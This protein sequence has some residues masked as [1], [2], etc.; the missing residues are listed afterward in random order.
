[1]KALWEKVKAF[2]NRLGPVLKIGAIVLILI[3]LG[4]TTCKVIQGSV[5][6]RIA[7]VETKL[8]LSDQALNESIINYKKL[9]AERKSIIKEAQERLDAADKKLSA[10][11][12]ANAKISSDLVAEKNKTKAMPNEELAVSLGTYVGPSEV[13]ALA[14]GLFS[15]TRIG[16]ENTRGIFLTSTAL[17]GKLTNCDAAREQ[18]GIKLVSLASELGGTANALGACKTALLT[19][20]EVITQLKKDISLWK[21]K[22][23]WA[24][25]KAGLPAVAVGVVIGYLVHK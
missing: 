4:F 17:A 1:M 14:S 23:R 18:D 7:K 3:L 8:A 16:A 25:I 10:L 21:A 12:K 11:M 24:W 5:N 20:E 15:M 22:N 13:S 2:W 19:N 9:E 6:S